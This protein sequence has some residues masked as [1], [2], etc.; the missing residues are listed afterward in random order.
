MNQGSP[1]LCIRACRVSDSCHDVDGH[2]IL[3]CSVASRAMSLPRIPPPPRST[4]PPTGDL[5]SL[6]TPLPADDRNPHLQVYT[7]PSADFS[8]PPHE[9]PP[10]TQHHTYPRR[11]PPRRL[12]QI[13]LAAGPTSPPAVSAADSGNAGFILPN[14]PSDQ[15]GEFKSAPT[16]PTAGGETKGSP[17]G[18]QRRMSSLDNLWKGLHLGPGSVGAF[19]AHQTSERDKEQSRA[20]DVFHED[21]E[22]HGPGEEPRGSP[23]PSQHGPGWRHSLASTLGGTLKAKSK[24]KTVL[25]PST[26]HPAS[27]VV[28]SGYTLHGLMDDSPFTSADTHTP[29]PTAKPISITHQSPFA[30]TASLAPSTGSSSFGNPYVNPLSGAPGFT[31]ADTYLA[32]SRPTPP[33]PPRAEDVQVREWSGT[34]LLGRREGTDV[35]LDQYAADAVS[36]S[37]T[38][39]G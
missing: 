4:P 31:R 27:P 35:V 15:F 34:L 25:G 21:D 32:A 9:S 6:D 19:P 7:G 38:M 37:L 24:W 3:Q 13:A 23:H 39:H 11:Q 29:T 10:R 14:S 22:G 8:Q 17:P 36:T 5:I 16:A 30:P 33:S 26:F 1:P 28:P 2:R 18:R 12:S 20:R